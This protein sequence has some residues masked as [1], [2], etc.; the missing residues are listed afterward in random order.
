MPTCPFCHQPASKRDGHDTFRRQR[1]ACR[2]CGRDFTVHT[3]SAFA[4]Y[5]WPSEVILLAVR[6]SLSHPLSATSVMELLAERGIDVSRRT[7]LRW[8]QTFGPLLAAEVRK[9]RRPL[10]RKCYVDEVFFFRGRD[11]HYLYRAVDEHRQ[12]VDVLFREHR[13]TESATAFFR[14]ALARTG[15]RP[16]QVISDHH[17]PYVK[18]IQEVFPEA[19]HVRTGLHRA[20]GETTKPIERSHVPTRDRLRASRGIKT[21]ATGQRFFEGFEALHALRRGHADLAPLAPDHQ[22]GRATKH[23]RVRAV[24]RAVTALGTRL[25][26]PARLA[27]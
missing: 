23:E 12:V 17:Q 27:A 5:R 20:S 4:G 14:Q 21:L 7:V 18:A 6:W 19:E 9:H 2:A 16:A 25:T 22:P 26:K 24:A 1:Y 8:V 3:G 13:D 10:G 11:K 15:W